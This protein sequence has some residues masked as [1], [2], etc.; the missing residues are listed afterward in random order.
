M[1][2]PEVCRVPARALML[3]DADCGFCTRTA[4]WVGRHLAVDVEIR[5][6]QSLD[7]GA[8]GVDPERAAREMPFVDTSGRVSYGHRAWAG[9][10]RTG[11][12]LLR[13]GGALLG[14]RALAPL[15]GAVYEWVA[16]HRHRMPGGTPTCALSSTAGAGESGGAAAA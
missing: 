2:E 12:P 9:I 8:W 15:A 11:G 14:S 1:A 5:P 7:L 4:R 3:Y 10:L 6:M 16:T 13:P